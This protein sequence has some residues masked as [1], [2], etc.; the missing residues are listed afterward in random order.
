MR[1]A[2]WDKRPPGA[3]AAPG[4]FVPTSPARLAWAY[5]RRSDRDV[6]PTRYRAETIYFRGAPQG[7]DG[8]VARFAV[9]A[10]A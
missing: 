1:E 6:L 3:G 7:S 10:P 8:L 2:Q 9:N 5:V 4:T